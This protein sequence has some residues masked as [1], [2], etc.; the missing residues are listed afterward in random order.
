MLESLQ[1]KGGIDSKNLNI[2]TVTG[3]NTTGHVTVKYGKNQTMS[4]IMRINL[5]KWIVEGY[6]NCKKLDERTYVEELCQS[7]C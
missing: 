3:R 1:E 7:K 2:M 6:V 5:V 4:C